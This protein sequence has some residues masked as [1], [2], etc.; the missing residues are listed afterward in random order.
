M[1]PLVCPSRI[2]TLD[3]LCSALSCLCCTLIKRNCDILNQL[4]LEE[5]MPNRSWCL[6][7]IP[8]NLQHKSRV[9]F[10]AEYS[11][12]NFHIR[13]LCLGITIFNVY[14]KDL[15]FFNPKT[16]PTGC[17]HSWLGQT[18]LSAWYILGVLFWEKK[19]MWQWAF[20]I[21]VLNIGYWDRIGWGFFI[22]DIGYRGR[23]RGYARISGVYIGHYI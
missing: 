4:N 7:N 17:H 20:L 11:L 8:L 23:Y 1:H 16:I 19:K 10:F 21:K 2:W 14:L 13:W 3:H 22:S 18:L 9:F 12:V 5:K 6:K 15:Y